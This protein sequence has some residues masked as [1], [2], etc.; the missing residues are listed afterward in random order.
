MTMTTD[1]PSAAPTGGSTTGR[2]VRVIGPVV[3]V[4]F[5]PD[6]MPALENALHVER[7]LGEDTAT[8]TLEVA[9]H[10]GDNMVRAV[11]MQPTDVQRPRRV[12]RRTDRLP[13]HPGALADSPPGS[14]LR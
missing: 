12:A 3:D 2:V 9:Q 10:I 13:R 8:L 7:T 14:S 5:S 11:S 4:E 6:T 1:T